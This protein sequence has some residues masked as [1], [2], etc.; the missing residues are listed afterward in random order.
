MGTRDRLHNEFVVAKLGSLRVG[1]PSTWGLGGGCVEDMQ[2]QTM[3]Q[4]AAQL[5]LRG[6][7]QALASKRASAQCAQCARVARHRTPKGSSRCWNSKNKNSFLVVPV[8]FANNPVCSRC[9]RPC[10]PRAWSPQCDSTTSDRLWWFRLLYIERNFE[11]CQCWWE[12]LRFS[13]YQNPTSF[14]PWSFPTRFSHPWVCR[15][16]RNWL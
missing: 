12:P 11:M 13:H 1:S 16:V 2:K 14:Y 4:E 9:K 8:I 6:L 10:P 15:N 5:P 7:R 3:C